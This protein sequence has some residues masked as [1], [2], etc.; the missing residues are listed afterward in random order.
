VTPR[1]LATMA[2]LLRMEGCHNINPHFPSEL[3]IRCPEMEILL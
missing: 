3:D 1:T 2:W